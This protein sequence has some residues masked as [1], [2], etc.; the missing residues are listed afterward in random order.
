L[1]KSCQK[2]VKNFVSPGKKNKKV[3]CPETKKNSKKEET[4]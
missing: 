2:V 3:N 1:S 4:T